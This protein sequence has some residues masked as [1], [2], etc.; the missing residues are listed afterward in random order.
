MNIRLATIKNNSKS[1][2]HKIISKSAE[3]QKRILICE[4][5]LDFSFYNSYNKTRSAAPD[6]LPFKFFRQRRFIKIANKSI[7]QLKKV[8]IN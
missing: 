3:I 4:S 1:N 8:L 2:I 7:E 5:P 6:V